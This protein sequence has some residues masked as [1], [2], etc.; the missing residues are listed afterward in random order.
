MKDKQDNLYF[1]DTLY[2]IF[3]KANDI[4]NILDGVVISTEHLIYGLTYDDK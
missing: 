3:L 1:S 2:K 4:K